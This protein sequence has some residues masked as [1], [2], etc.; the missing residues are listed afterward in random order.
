MPEQK[1]NVEDRFKMTILQ[2]EKRILDIETLI[3]TIKKKIEEIDLKKIEEFVKKAED[4]EDLVMVEQAG[5]WELKKLLEKT[6]KEKIELPK[7]ILRRVE[8]IEEDF[9][10]LKK[11]LKNINRKVEKLER[12]KDIVPSNLPEK[13]EK[14]KDT[15]EEFS[16]LKRTVREMKRKL[17]KLPQALPLRLEKVEQKVKEF[18]ESGI[19]T[20]PEFR[21]M[22]TKLGELDEK[23]SFLKSKTYSIESDT[24]DLINRVNGLERISED[25][26]KE[27]RN[28]SEE[29]NEISSIK[30]ATDVINDL[31]FRV[32]SIE[33]L[34]KELKIHKSLID[35]LADI[36]EMVVKKDEIEN[37]K[38]ELRKFAKI[39]PQKEAIIATKRVNEIMKRIGFLESRLISLEN[40]ISQLKGTEPVVLE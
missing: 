6:E 32:Q 14:I 8:K 24:K 21:M 27:F 18:T 31:Q 25:L 40:L 2:I 10:E 23:V 37:I 36:E 20:E 5:V 38:E 3:S 12:L 13:L 1:E 22:R 39:E 15:L 30:I 19:P 34:L 33:T 7:N 28:I 16:D 9:T 29:L 4:L 11:V 17:S 35:R 26:I